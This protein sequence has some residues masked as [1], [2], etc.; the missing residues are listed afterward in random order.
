MLLVDDAGD[1]HARGA[2]GLAEP[3][4]AQGAQLGGEV[5]DALDDRV[6]PAVAAGGP[7][8]LVQQL[9][10]GPAR[11]AF[12]PVPPTSRAMTCLTGTVWPVD[13]GEV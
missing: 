6:G 3:V 12:I 2:G 9:A 5:Q 1:R 7:A 13:P 8:G 10:P 4:D 11:A